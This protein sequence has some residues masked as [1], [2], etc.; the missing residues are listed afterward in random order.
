MNTTKK[1]AGKTAALTAGLL[2]ATLAMAG[3]SLGRQPGAPIGGQHLTTYTPPAAASVD[4]VVWNVFEGEPQTINPYYSA[5][6]NSNM[7][8]ANMCENLMT[9]TPD[10]QIKP[11]LASSYA[12]PDPLHWVYNLRSDVSFW[13]GAPMTAEDVAWSMQKNMTDKTS[14][15]SYLYLNVKAIAVTGAHQVTVTLAHP[16]Y[17][18]NEELASFA[19]V[20]VEKQYYQAHEK[21]F[22]TSNG[23]LM[24]T[25]PFAFGAWTQG[26]SITLKANP[27][28]WNKALQPKV[29]TLVFSF[30][31][32]DNAIT[33]G[34]LNGQIDGTFNTPTSGYNQLKNSGVGKL[35]TGAAPFNMTM[36]YTNLQG[37]MGNPLM[38]QALQEAI[39]WNGITNTV[40]NG[41]G[42]QLTLSVPPAAY[43]FAK[44]Q[45]TA[46]AKSL[47][48][49]A[50]AQYDAAKALLARVP[51]SVRTQPVTMV[52]TNNA[53]TQAFGLAIKDAATRIGMKFNLKVV[54]GTGY[55]SYLYDP[56]ARAGIDILYTQFWPNIPNPIDWILTTAVPGGSFNFSNYDGVTAA[57]NAAIGTADVTSRAKQVAAIEKKLYDDHGP[58]VAGID[59]LNTT[60]LNNRITGVPAS[61][62]YVYYPW[63]AYLGGAR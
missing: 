33:S 32:D 37:P 29:K 42:N 43:G 48:A 4:K 14:F 58:L 22:G 5:D 45:L 25:G 49:P 15:Y 2:A 1:T 51:E 55:S 17:L 12:N 18:F 40:F 24:C 47:P 27:T 61:F 31:T 8:N 16:N 63:A 26:Q 60:F 36:V 38:R 53:D 39:D 6:Y 59:L 19:G 11:N 41:Q 54:P 44:N 57:V 34:L 10:F 50:S 28:Y 23:G 13:D 3:C 62:D 56:K 30:V 46:L 52:V 21:A 35:Y 7:I 20:V 9:Q